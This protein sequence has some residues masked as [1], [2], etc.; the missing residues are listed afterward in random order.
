ML[1]VILDADKGFENHSNSNANNV[2]STTYKR[3]SQ[4]KRKRLAT[5]LLGED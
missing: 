1:N 5:V 4:A 2:P 3:K